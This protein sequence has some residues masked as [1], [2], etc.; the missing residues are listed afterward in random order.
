V[1]KLLNILAPRALCQNEKK[2]RC[3]NSY[4]RGVKSF[5]TLGLEGPPGDLGVELSHW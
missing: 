5:I 1:K 3:D 4:I 2:I